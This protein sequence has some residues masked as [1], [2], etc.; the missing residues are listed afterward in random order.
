MSLQ[1]KAQKKPLPKQR[2]FYIFIV[3]YSCYLTITLFTV[4][5]FSLENLKKY[6]PAFLNCT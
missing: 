5:P 1:T 6:I 2:P 3:L 4:E